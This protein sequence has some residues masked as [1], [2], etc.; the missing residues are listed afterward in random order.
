MA[1]QQNIKEKILREFETLTQQ[2]QQTLL[3]IVENYLH[4]KADE[5]DWNKLPAEWKKRIEESL[6]QADEGHLILHEDA[7]LNL[8][9]KYGLNG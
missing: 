1:L 8:R 2:E 9:K 4:N 5:T 6:K 3:G 7:V